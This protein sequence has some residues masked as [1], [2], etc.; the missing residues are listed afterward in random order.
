[1]AGRATAEQ[2]DTSARSLYLDGAR[3]FEAGEHERA[4]AYFRRAWLESARPALL[5]NMGV[6]LERLERRREALEQYRAYLAAVP[7]ASDREAVRATI[8]RLEASSPEPA[9][10]PKVLLDPAATRPLEDAGAR[11]RRRLAIALTATAGLVV[12][13]V[14]LVVGLGLGLPR[15]PDTTRPPLGPGAALEARF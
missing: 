6:V 2:G 10:R 9:T 4:Y 5:F 8:A 7:D 15:D 3:A 14:G 12:V 11:R 13:G 1:L